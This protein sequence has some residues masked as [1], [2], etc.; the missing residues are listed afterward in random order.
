MSTPM[1]R[2]NLVGAL[3]DNVREAGLAIASDGIVLSPGI[4]GADLVA[5]KP[6]SLFVF[7]KL[8]S[9]SGSLLLDTFVPGASHTFG[10]AVMTLTL[11]GTGYVMGRYD[12]LSAALGFAFKLTTNANMIVADL[13]FITLNQMHAGQGWFDA[14]SAQNGTASSYTG[15]DASNQAVNGAFTAGSGVLKLGPAQDNRYGS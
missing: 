3:L 1:G 14:G 12:L 10:S 11:S 15:T 13:C 5:D 8:S 2:Q 7:C 9:G 6:C 4:T